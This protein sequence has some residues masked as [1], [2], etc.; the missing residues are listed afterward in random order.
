MERTRLDLAVMLFP[1][2]N[3]D[4]PSSTTCRRLTFA[5]VCR[6][7]SAW[8]RRTSRLRAALAIYQAS[9]QEVTAA[10]EGCCHPAKASTISTASTPLIRDSH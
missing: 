6:S 2:F 7:G 5:R 10:W 8:A 9:Q 3:Q 1:D 4:S